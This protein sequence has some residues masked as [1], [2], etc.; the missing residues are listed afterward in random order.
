M[1][2]IVDFLTWGDSRG[3][4]PSAGPRA[5][6]V[7]LSLAVRLARHDAYA[8]ARLLFAS[9]PNPRPSRIQDPPLGNGARLPR[10]ALQG[11]YLRTIYQPRLPA[12]RLP[13]PRPSRLPTYPARPRAECADDA[14]CALSLYPRPAL[15]TRTHRPPY[16]PE[17]RHCASNAFGIAAVIDLWLLGPQHTISSVSNVYDSIHRPRTPT[18][19]IEALPIRAKWSVHDG[20]AVSNWSG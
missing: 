6:C 4:P 20:G 5:R 12:P 15:G 11:A 19:A 1:R 10:F 14:L 8:L 7:E 17:L 3:F 2:D 18:C 13:R 16:Y 9:S